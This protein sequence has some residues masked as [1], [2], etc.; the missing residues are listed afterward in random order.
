M[1]KLIVPLD[2]STSYNT[3]G[4]VES[5]LPQPASF[6]S[7]AHSQISWREGSYLWS[8]KISSAD[9]S[10]FTRPLA[11][12]SP[13]SFESRGHISYHPPSAPGTRH[14]NVDLNLLGLL[15]T[16]SLSNG[17]LMQLLRR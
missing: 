11:M 13:L 2:S 9:K 15:P 3:G 17:C 5:I 8:L 7:S 12:L 1:E 10:N 6:L 16:K 14:V 4:L